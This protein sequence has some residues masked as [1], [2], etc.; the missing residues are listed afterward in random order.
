MIKHILKI[1]W[2]QRKNNTWIFLELVVVI[3]ALWWMTD[4]LYVD[5]RTYYSPLGYDITNTWRFKLSKLNPGSPDFIKEEDYVSNQTEDLLTLMSHIR[6]HPSVEEV[7]AT[8]YSCPYSYGNSWRGL[9][10]IDGDTTIASERS[11]QIRN[12][13]I[14]YF[15]V[16]R[17]KDKNGNLITPQ[18]EGIHNPIIIS[19]DMEELFYHGEQAKGRKVKYSEAEEAI[20]IAAVS[21]PIRVDDYSRSDPCFFNCAT[22]SGF[23]DL[24]TGFGAESAELCV[25]MKQY[26]TLDDMNKLLAEMGER[27][28]VNNLYVYGVRATE[29]F[30]NESLGERDSDRNKQLSLMLFLLVN[31]FFG[32]VGT[33][34]LRTQYRQAELGLRIAVGA[35]RVSLK[36]YLFIEGLCLL[37]LTL[38]LVALFIANMAYMD[39]L[40]SYRIAFSFVRFFITIG[41]TYLL[42]SGMI[43]LGIWFPVQKVNKIAPAEALHYE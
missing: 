32:I 2:T 23:V 20:T 1:I 22:G 34:W 7:C 24:V 41:G 28:T 25:R 33:F 29:E 14:E 26:A 10:P 40:D 36:K 21:A 6:Q 4:Q 37:I 39:K 17:I 30:R 19:E 16:F 12:V 18:I 38:P 42:M 5:L 13:S 8:Y 43:C 27:L 35:S 31:V 9:T 15:D 11:F 3:C